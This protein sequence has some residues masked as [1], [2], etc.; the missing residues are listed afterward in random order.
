MDSDKSGSL[1]QLLKESRKE[2]DEKLKPWWEALEKE[3]DRSVGIVAA[4]FLDA[5]LEQMIRTFYVKDRHVGDLFKN[6]HMLMTFFS[7]INIAYYSGY[8][9][10]VIY[11]DL[12]IICRIRNRLAHGLSSGL[13]FT[14]KTLVQLVQACEL[15]PRTMDEVFA[16]KLKYTLIVQQIADHLLIMT[17]VAPKLRP[18]QFVEFLNMEKWNLSE[19]TLTK[20][21][22]EEIVKRYESAAELV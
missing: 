17:K 21:K 5:L 16:P 22:I 1:I 9:P 18:P 2:S 20:S 8:I 10:K 3:S 7:K 12:K 14:D 6:D 19:A 11:H 13:D 4:S 15:R